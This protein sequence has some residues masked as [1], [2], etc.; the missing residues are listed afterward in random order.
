M[1]IRLA[2]L[3]I[4]INNLY[5]YIEEMCKD[6]IISKPNN[7][8]IS[9]NVTK[10]EI[11]E[12]INKSEELYPEFYIE[13]LLVYRKIALQIVNFDGFLLHGSSF[14]I[15]D[16]AFLLCAKSGVGKTTHSL[17]LANYLKDRFTWINGDK[18]L[19]R[20]I[21]GIPYCYGTPWCGKEN[22]QNNIKVECKAIGFIERS[23]E[24]FVLKL[25]KKEVFKKLI[26]QLLINDNMEYMN[27]AFVLFNEFIN[28]IDAYIINCNMEK[29]APIVS[30]KEIFSK[31]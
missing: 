31:Y 18:P 6:Y 19:I 9:I 3:N 2:E 30:Y 25:E 22:Y 21:D 24:N 28:Y 26:H 12:E 29:D 8:D 27:K 20:I 13:T 4:E 14:M 16:K 10:E 7:I 15:N 5:K 23:K 17:L 1:Y 11:Q